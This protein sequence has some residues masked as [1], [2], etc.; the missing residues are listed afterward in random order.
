VAAIAALLLSM[1]GCGMGASLSDL[2]TIDDVI[3]HTGV[4]THGTTTNTVQ[5]TATGTFAPGDCN[6]CGTTS[7]TVDGAQWTTTDTE[8]TTITKKGLATCVG[9]SVTPATV[10]ASAKNQFGTMV[11]HSAELMCK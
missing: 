11:S 9:A 10:T 1:A 8:N 4:A 3:P 2:V 6:Y 7:Q 5:F